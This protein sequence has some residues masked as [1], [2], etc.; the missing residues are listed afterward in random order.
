MSPEP[1][2]VGSSWKRLSR[3]S[4]P[5][6]AEPRPIGYTRFIHSPALSIDDDF[7]GAGISTLD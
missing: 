7:D 3:R 5:I 4:N 6:G 1:N 2:P